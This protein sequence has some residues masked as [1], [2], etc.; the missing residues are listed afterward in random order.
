MRGGDSSA[1]RAYNERLI[2]DAIRSH[3]PLSKAELA[4]VTGLSA[5]AA[6]VIV[7][8]LLADGMLLEN[9]KVRGRIGQPMTPLALNP[10]GAF[11]VGLKIGRRSVD[12]ARR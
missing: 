2:Y 6:A 3:G 7:R 11:A 4:R 10:R 12:A 9:A 1:L 8:D 5:Q